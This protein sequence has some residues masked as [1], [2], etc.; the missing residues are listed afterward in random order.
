MVRE[1][2][3]RKGRQLPAEGRR[4]KGREYRAVAV[5]ACDADVLPNE[6]RLLAASDERALKEVFDTERH[7]LYVAATR[8]RERLCLSATNPPSEFIEDLI[9]QNDDR[10]Q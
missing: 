6:N 9:T 5:M 1:V 10:F 2:P 8:A 3:R 4:L 7:L